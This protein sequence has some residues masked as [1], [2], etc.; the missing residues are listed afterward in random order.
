MAT[1][2]ARD[3][4]DARALALAHE[5]GRLLRALEV[6]LAEN[7]SLEVDKAE[8]SARLEE[9]EITMAEITAHSGHSGALSQEQLLGIASDDDD[10]SNDEEID[11]EVD[12]AAAVT[13]T[14]LQEEAAALRSRVEELEGAVDA[15]Q[16]AFD[17]VNGR[18]VDSATRADAVAAAVQAQHRQLA[19]ASS[20]IQAQQRQLDQAE[21]A[22]RALKAQLAEA[23]GQERELQGRHDAVQ[24]RHDEAAEE[25]E[26]LEVDALL[27]VAC[28]SV[29]LLTFFSNPFKQM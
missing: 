9:A 26:Y 1:Q 25:L 22:V 4:V 8:L 18:Y 23:A 2:V 28:R 21:A 6:S 16:R 10:D 13:V 7:A 20:V 27:M 14:A 11:D 19:E 12:R 3:G 24:E 17:D 29:T 5:N 15:L